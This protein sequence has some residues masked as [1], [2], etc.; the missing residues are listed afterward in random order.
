MAWDGPKG[1]Q[2]DFFLYTNPDLAD[3]FGRVDLNFDNLYFLDLL[4]P[5]LSDFKLLDFQISNRRGTWYD[6]ALPAEAALAA[7]LPQYPPV[8]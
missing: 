8:I 3:I 7:T 6:T 2:D 4:D 5:I 1:G